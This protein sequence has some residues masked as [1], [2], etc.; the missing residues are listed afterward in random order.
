MMTRRAVL[1]LAALIGGIGNAHAQTPDAAK[2]ADVQAKARAEGEL[3]VTGPPAPPLRAA[4]SAAFQARHGISLN[5]IGETTGAVMARID[6]ESKAGHLTIDAHIGGLPTCWVFAARNEVKD[7]NGM[8]IDPAILQPG[9]WKY[10]A[11]KLD[12]MNANATGPND[13]KC[14]FQFTEWVFTF[15]FRNTDAVPKIDSWNDL[16]QPQFKNKIAAFDPRSSGPGETPVGY[17]G[18]I[19]GDA[20]VKSLFIGQTVRFSADSRQLAEWVATGEYSLG[21]GLV[22][23]AVEIYRKQGLPIAAVS[24]KEG[25]GPLTGGS[26]G[27]SLGSAASVARAASTALSGEAA[28]RRAT[29]RWP[30][31]TTRTTG[32]CRSTPAWSKASAVGQ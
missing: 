22:P 21:I 8:L 9:I 7:I 30:R 18:K 5:Y 15:L 28:S 14:A 1:L 26:R 25:G 4:L 11:P 23:F 19:M 27:A 29:M 12:E 3:T 13:P 2:W 24:P 6:T 16:L 20:Y 31:S 17:L 32:P 10:G